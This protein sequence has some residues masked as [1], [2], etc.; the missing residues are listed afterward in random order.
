MLAHFR[1][2]SRFQPDR[3][4]FWKE[5]IQAAQVVIEQ[6][7]TKFS[8]VTGLLPDFVQS[9]G[10]GEFRPA[11]PGFLVCFLERSKTVEWSEY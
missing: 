2:F 11:Q 10:H 8:P 5:V 6:I 3:A 4:A 1:A 7:Q 9:D